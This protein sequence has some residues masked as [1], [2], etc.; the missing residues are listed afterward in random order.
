MNGPK[1]RNQS[2]G[3]SPRRA[4]SG[5]DSQ[6]VAMVNAV[7]E[8]RGR[9]KLADADVFAASVGGVCKRVESRRGKATA[10]VCA[11]VAHAVASQW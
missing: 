4:V 8:R 11:G 1:R 6:R 5:L 7:V 9:V 3:G 10:N 2:V